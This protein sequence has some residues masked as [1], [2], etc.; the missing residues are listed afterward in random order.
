MQSRGS[1]VCGFVAYLTGRFEAISPCWAIVPWCWLQF[2]WM[3]KSD[4]VEVVQI[5]FFNIGEIGG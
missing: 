5:H 3:K 4:G 1:E 2:G